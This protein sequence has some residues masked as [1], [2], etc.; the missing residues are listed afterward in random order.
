V[1]ESDTLAHLSY[2]TY[3]S[4]K[5]WRDIAEHNGIDDPMRVAKGRKVLLPSPAELPKRGEG[6]MVLIDEDAE[7]LSPGIDEDY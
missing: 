3:Q 2:R 6:G 1:L 7:E 4:A 5:H